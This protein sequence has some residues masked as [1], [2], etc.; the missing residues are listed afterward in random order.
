MDPQDHMQALMR[1]I[2]AAISPILRLEDIKP[3]DRAARGCSQGPNAT[4][5]SLI[6]SAWGTAFEATTIRVRTAIDLML[7]P[8]TSARMAVDALHGHLERQREIA[9]R[10][11]ACGISQPLS[12]DAL[13]STAH[14]SVDPDAA[15]TL[16]GYAGSVRQARMWL[17][18]QMAY[19]AS[20]IGPMGQSG[21]S[22]TR[23]VIRIMGGLIH[24]PFCLSPLVPSRGSS[25]SP[26]NAPVWEHDAIYIQEMIPD[27]A[28]IALVGRRLDTVISGSPI[29]HRIIT[30]AETS[31]FLGLDDTQL[32][33]ATELIRIDDLIPPEAP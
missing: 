3:I 31:D 21:P 8:E 2:D 26:T 30:H 12:G 24:I 28:A 10:A 29:G 17:D 19:H 18:A 13:L 7:D 14:L 20:D 11:H 27:S 9:G 32:R 23:L 1:H 5:V 4:P 22:E 33:I 6:L 15:H 16:I 25:V